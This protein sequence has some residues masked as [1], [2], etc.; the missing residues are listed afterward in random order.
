[1][2]SVDSALSAVISAPITVVE[3]V[4]SGGSG[5]PAASTRTVDDC[6]L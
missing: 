1:M 2:T 5:L 4:T 3:V 6:D